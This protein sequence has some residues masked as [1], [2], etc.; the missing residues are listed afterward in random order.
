MTSTPVE[1]SVTAAELHQS[2]IVIDGLSY[3][4]DGPS[5]RLDPRFVTATNVTA[6]ET[7]S[8]FEDASREINDVR[9]AAEQDPGALV[10]LSAADIERAKQEG[11]VGV[12]IGLQASLPI[13][14]DLSRISLLHALGVRII[15]LTY[16]DRT[17][18]GDG[19]VE[20]V[21]GGLSVFGRAMIEEMA[22]VGMALDLS[23][24]GRRTSLDVIEAATVPPMFSHANPLAL[25]ENVRNLTDEQMRKVADRGGMV[26]ICCWAP[27]CW[28]NRPGDPPTIADYV[29]HIDYAVELIGADR[30]GIATDSACTMDQA[31]AA[32]H[33]LD[34]AAAFPEIAQSY[35]DAVGPNTHPESLPTVANLL[36]I[37][38]EL[39]RRGYAEDDVRS[40]IGGNF[41][42]HLRE[43]WGG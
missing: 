3:Y 2:A 33:S 14:T 13:E 11:K 19:C 29:D 15:Q 21:D 26:G 12:I 10:V 27:L 20:P 43:V 5:D 32:Q 6:C 41:L 24:V 31:W 30:V 8:W 23:H 42:R 4:Y 36:P 39:L 35:R 34:F 7:A 40:I 16:N 22:R 9:E 38:E 28:K 37:T 1:L 18:A 25:T 17:W